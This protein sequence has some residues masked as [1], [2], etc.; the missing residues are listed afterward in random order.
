VEFLNE[1]MERTEVLALEIRQY[2]EEGGDRVTLVPRLIGDTEAARQTKSPRPRKTTSEPELL[3][4]IREKNKNRPEVAERVIELYEWMKAKGARAVWGKGA[5]TRSVSLYLGEDADPGKSNPVMVWISPRSISIPFHYIVDK[6]Q[7][8]E[9]E[10]LATLARQ[11][12][13]VAS[14]LEGIEARNYK[15]SADMK[16]EVVLGSD[17]GLEAWKHMLLEGTRAG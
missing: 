14:H 7:E 9:L 1:Q 13:G 8:T 10:R 5:T 4:A 3:D 6:R 12:P 11:V 16:P 15:V 17:E 2:V